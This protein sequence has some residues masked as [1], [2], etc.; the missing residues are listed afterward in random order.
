MAD[1]SGD[2]VEYVPMEAGPHQIYITYGDLDV[3]GRN[4][5]CV[6]SKLSQFRLRLTNL[7]LN[8]TN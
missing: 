7:K 2:V 6:V 3:A 5:F 1:G 4:H 8:H